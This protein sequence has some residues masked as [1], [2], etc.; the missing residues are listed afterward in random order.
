MKSILL[1]IPD[2]VHRELVATAQHQSR[3]LNGQILYYLKK[4][5]NEEGDHLPIGLASLPEWKPEIV[6][7][8]REIERIR[9][10]ER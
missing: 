4:S 3:S 1:R 6:I 7:S 8:D 2:E 9:E 5:L 10:D